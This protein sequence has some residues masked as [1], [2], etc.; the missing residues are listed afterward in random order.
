MAMKGEI[1]VKNHEGTQ[2]EGPRENGSSL[3]FEF[4]HQVYLP[5]DQEENRVQGSRRIGAFTIIKDIDKLTPQLYEMVC[6]GRNCQEVLITL[7]K[8][9]DEGDE[10][11]YFNY[12]LENA[13]IVSVKNFMPSTKYVENENV[14]HMEK[15]EFLAK[16]FTW[17]FMEGGVIYSEEAF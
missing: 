11:P 10:S 14:G 15:V 5:F 17:E 6:L 2:L 4:D 13:K 1:T 16:T 12:K 8:I 7:Y 9:N 3:V